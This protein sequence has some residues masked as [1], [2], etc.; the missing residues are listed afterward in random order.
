MVRE[1]DG[2]KGE[3]ADLVRALAYAA[4]CLLSDTD[5]E[6]RLGEVLREVGSAVGATRAALYEIHPGDPG[7]ARF[8][9]E[10]EW[11]ID[12]AAPDAGTRAFPRWLLAL[13]QGG[14]IFGPVTSLPVGERD[15]LT[16]EGI[17]AIL[18]VSVP[19]LT[20][21]HRGALVFENAGTDRE[22][23]QPELQFAMAIA[24]ALGAAFIQERA[25]HDL[26]NA[27]ARYR[28]IVEAQTELICRFQP[29]GRVTF[30]NEAYGR[31]LGLSPVRALEVSLWN[32][33][34][35]DA[36]RMIQKAIAGLVP[37]GLPATVL[38]RIVL[39]DGSD[40]WVQWELVA[41]PRP[42]G[43]LLE[44]QAVGAD[45]TERQRLMVQLEHEAFF[46]ELTGIA[47][48]RLFE[49]RGRRAIAAARAR[50]RSAALLLIDLDRFKHLNDSLGHAAGDEALVEIA[51]RL[52][53]EVR[54]VDTLARMGGDEYAILLAGADEAEAA[55]LGHRLAASIGQSLVVQGHPVRLSASIG[56]ALF[57]RAGR[58]LED[59][60]RHADT[61]MYRA[62]SEGGGVRF[63]DETI[64]GP[65]QER[66]GLESDLREALEAGQL[67]I[68]FQPVRRVG[69]GAIVGAEALCRWDHLVRG[70]VPPSTFLPAIEGTNLAEV[71]DFWVLRR[72]LRQAG[73][74][75]RAGWKGWISVNL[76]P[77]T[78]VSPTLL[79][80][81]AAAIEESAVDPAA[82]VIEMTEHALAEPCKVL[83][84]FQG[85][86]ESG[87]RLAIDDFGAGHASFAYLE[88][89]P[90]D[91]LKVDQQFVRRPWRQLGSGTLVQTMVGLGHSLGL[92]VLAEGIETEEQLASVGESG[93]DLG[94]GFLLGRPLPSRAFTDLVFGGPAGQ[95]VPRGT[96]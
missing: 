83:P 53:R 1:N 69:T 85:L 12:P 86:R 81:V 51:R 45:V 82:V 3:R 57:P 33:L 17:G 50:P 78:L 36:V 52:E 55:A 67:D 60:L 22:W 94:Q 38:H 54:S 46:D 32:A 49:D 96:A 41:I 47:N 39:H 84:V 70:A 19:A 65:A 35:P 24:H 11:R 68:H 76:V 48:R 29:D 15:A 16:L 72:A 8:S 88:N 2:Q 30:A 34:P 42:T 21:G 56:V 20:S 89:L 44:Y 40:M 18:A 80:E 26:L 93:C 31:R 73:A 6:Q 27:E 90:V 61:A 23:A 37:G 74:W 95:A 5:C 13:S 63:F 77:R 92:Q 14:A 64:D 79:R 7:G 4:E 87:V 9:L 59:L 25:R 71:L 62:K 43:G 91:M 75:R 28:A 66:L 10:A 58:T